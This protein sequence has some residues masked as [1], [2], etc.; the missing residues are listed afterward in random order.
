MILRS[1]FV[2]RIAI[3][4]AI[5]GAA[6]PSIAL[7]AQAA[8]GQSVVVDVAPGLTVVDGAIAV[9]VERRVPVGISDAF[10][11]SVGAVYAWVKVKNLGED[12]SLTMVWKKDGRTTI[13][14]SLGVGHSWGWKTWTK[15][16]ISDKDTGSWT[17]EILDVHE[18][19]LATLGFTID[20]GAADVSLVQ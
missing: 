1:P 8:P 14:H 18:N 12:T 16:G 11:P 13:R 3:A 10:K 9:K 15:K 4:L 7:A 5:G 2:R 6:A 20:P 19:V 17:V